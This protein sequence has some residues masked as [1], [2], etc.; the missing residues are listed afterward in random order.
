MSACAGPV[1]SKAAPSVTP[2]QWFCGKR[3]DYP[4]EEIVL[5][6]LFALMIQ[7]LSTLRV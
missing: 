3:D 1:I 2:T 4:G 5:G 7:R 6:Q